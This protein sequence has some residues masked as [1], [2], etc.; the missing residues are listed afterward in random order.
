M[1]HEFKCLGVILVFATLIMLGNCDVYA[2]SIEECNNFEAKMENYCAASKIESEY[3]LQMERVGKN[4]YKIS[5]TSNKLSKDSSDTFVVKKIVGEYTGDHKDDISQL[6]VTKAHSLVLKNLKPNSSNVIKVKLKLTN[7]STNFGKKC[8]GDS[9]AFS[10]ANQRLEEECDYSGGITY[11]LKVRIDEDL[12]KTVITSNAASRTDNLAVE[13]STTPHSDFN[14]FL[15]VAIDKTEEQRKG[16]Q[17]LKCDANSTKYTYLNGRKLTPAEVNEYTETNTTNDYKYKNINVYKSTSN[18]KTGT[19]VYTYNRSGSIKKVRVPNVCEQSCTEVVKVEYGAPVASK[20]GLCFDY[21]F[22]ITSYT[23]CDTKFGAKKP[24]KTDYTVCTPKPQCVSRSGAVHTQGGPNEDFESCIREC[25]GG[26]Y[27]RS[28]SDKCYK[29]VYSTGIKK[30]ADLNNTSLITNLANTDP[31]KCSDSDGCYYRVGDTVYWQ[32]KSENL[33]RW[34]R[35]W[36]T[37]HGGATYSPTVQFPGHTYFILTTGKGAGIWKATDCNENCSW[38]DDNCDDSDYLN[39]KQATDDYERNL[40]MYDRE[41]EQCIAKASCNSSTS[42][43]TIKVNYATP[44]GEETI[45]FPK[46]GK[47]DSVTTGGS[48]TLS[49]SNTTLTTLVN[50]S[51]SC[52]ATKGSPSEWY[53][54]EWTFPG[55]WINNKTGEI[56]YNKPSSSEGWHQ[57]KNKF[58]IPL[59]AKSVNTKWWEWNKIG[60]SCYSDSNGDFKSSLVSEI[61]NNIIGSVRNFGHYGDG[62][63]NKTGWN[64]DIK[65]F[66]ALRNEICEENDKGC[67]TT[68]GGDTSSGGGSGDNNKVGVDNYRFRV[69]TTSDLFPN[70][71]GSS[72]T[73][74]DYMRTGRT[75]GFNWSDEAKNDKNSKYQVDPQTLIGKIQ[76]RK[77]LIYSDANKSKY[78]DYEFTLDQ[79]AL[80]KIRDYTKNHKEKTNDNDNRYKETYTNFDNGSIDTRNGVAAYS[81]PLIRSELSGIT[82]K[83]GKRVV[84]KRGNIGINND[85]E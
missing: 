46:I 39:P 61:Q 18:K 23:K 68:P 1:K 7:P 76:E 63:N 59:D 70:T 13:S 84:S 64:F 56:Q 2:A 79:N 55:T 78:L 17:V 24:N 51:G 52:N 15:G 43:Y 26:K 20:A 36:S 58:C 21:Q 25:D 28:C 80:Q 12:G 73:T 22:K 16:T 29:Q 5:V 44:S 35:V 57:E 53:Q 83:D 49:D 72:S 9:D 19:L 71:N 30:I 77:S 40:E 66:Y 3:G 69:V 67:C 37:H 60:N 6:K 48:N 54:S 45:E 42:T 32:S 85:N 82:T 74:E 31:E 11:T 38:S 75:P 47:N 34:Y 10:G 62:D 14:K 8:L 50:D 4:K 65:C 81:S 33:G 41:K 27:T